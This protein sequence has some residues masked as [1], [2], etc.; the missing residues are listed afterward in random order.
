VRIP[1]ELDQ[2]VLMFIPTGA[3]P[4]DAD[5]YMFL[6]DCAVDRVSLQRG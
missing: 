2:A 5:I 3:E 1:N 6:L 4:D